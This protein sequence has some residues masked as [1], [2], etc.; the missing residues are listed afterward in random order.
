M[1]DHKPQHEAFLSVGSSGD[2]VRDLHHR[3]SLAGF[4]VLGDEVT[5]F[6]FSSVTEAQVRVFQSTRR[7]MEDGVVGPQTLAAL[8]EASFQLG[9]RHL[10]LHVPMMRGDD[11][12]DLQ[13]RLGVL[14]FDAGRVDGIFGPDTSRSLLDFQRNIGLPSD[15]I[16]GVSTV[17]ELH[18]LAG[19]SAG[20]TPVVHVRELERLRQRRIGLDGRRIA[21]GQFGA[22]GALATAIARSL[23][24][25]GA[26]VLLLDHPEE[27]N[28]AE[29]ANR[30]EAELYLGLRVKNDS[31]SSLAFFAT[32]GFHSE[33]G[34][35]L[36]SFCATNL[37]PLNQAEPKLHGMRLP[38]LRRTRMPA[39]LCLL[40]P[41]SLVVQSTA[42]L[43]EAF[44]LAITTWM[45]NP[46]ETP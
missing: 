4:E 35:Q 9:D 30:F 36:A 16:T 15:G 40:G 10:Y 45:T 37:T 23:R 28:Q 12:A 26:N 6:S 13:L 25:L 19:R 33:G 17:Q 8:V 46:E 38:A 29:I 7:L 3:L 32:E 1:A 21:L 11:V 43:A 41:P 24:V 31:Q 18:Q 22:C 5:A 14:G 27:S 42:E 34:R 39:V 44:S 2:L 20:S